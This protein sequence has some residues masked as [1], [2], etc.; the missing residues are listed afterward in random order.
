MK[1]FAYTALDAAGRKK[2]G[3][4]DAETK[5]T[6][7]AKVAS[8][9]KFV[10]DIQ[11]AEEKVAT[12]AVVGGKISR[13]DLALFTR[14]LADLSAAGLPLDRVLKVI[15]E[16]SESPL[17]AHIVE[18]VLENV[19]G[20]M[21]V[22]EALAQHP[23]YF[24]EV[25]TQTLRAGE[26]SGQFPEVAGRLADFQQMEVT[27]RSQIASAMVYPIVLTVVAVGVVVFLLTFVV[28]RLSGVFRDLGGDLPATTRILLATTDFLTSNGLT[29]LAG[30]IVTVLA[31]RAWFA[32]PG[33]A[34]FRDMTVLRAP[35]LGKIVEKAVV[36]RYSRVLGML[37]YGGVPILESLNLAG[38]STGNR[39]FAQHSEKVRE[40][41]REGRSIADSMRDASCFPPVLTHMVAIGEETGDLPKMLSRVSDSLDFE[42]DNGIRRLMSLFEPAIV[43]VMGSFVGFVVLSVLLPI[44]QAQ[45]LVK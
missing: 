16:Q 15:S 27:R 42:V 45:N 34:L 4:V 11:E 14:R 1:T 28:P 26:A 5:Q 20:G 12:K 13:S 10:V 30:I 29:L 31:L 7:I 21:P 18:S 19:R 3:F 25:Y 37:V 22:S 2:S 8:E 35:L 36:S 23:K 38:L 17:L 33:G 40:D 9:G 44:Y 39:V 24:P 41:V 43:I 32:T 6:A